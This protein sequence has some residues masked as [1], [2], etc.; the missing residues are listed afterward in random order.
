MPGELKT[1]R[2]RG[3]KVPGRRNGIYKGPGAGRVVARVEKARGSEQEMSQAERLG[4]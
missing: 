3:K 4:D 2:G 1:E